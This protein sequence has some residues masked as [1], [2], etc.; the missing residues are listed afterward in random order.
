MFP[1]TIEAMDRRWKI[2][3]RVLTDKSE[4]GGPRED[5]ELS[6][7]WL[8][9]KRR[10]DYD[11]FV[12][13]GRKPKNDARFFRWHDSGDLQSID[14]YGLIASIAAHTPRVT[15]W[16]PTKEYRL[17]NQ[18]IESENIPGNL[19]IRVSAPMVGKIPNSLIAASLKH[20]NV[21]LS[22][23]DDNGTTEGF[24]RCEAYDGE[25]SDHGCGDCRD[26][27]DPE[28]QVSYDFRT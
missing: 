24:A 17:V 9:N 13:L 3:Q 2:L 19:V 12:K 16:L 11:R 10:A 26:C 15:H 5:F 4:F 27:W 21:C 18:V 20:P 28:T 1:S 25:E 6:F 23:A 22:S 14:H 7:V 8:L